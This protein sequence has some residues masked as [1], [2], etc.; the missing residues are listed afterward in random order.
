MVYVVEEVLAWKDKIKTDELQEALEAFI[1]SQVLIP[2]V[3]QPVGLAEI[4]GKS[5]KHHLLRKF[6]VALEQ[7]KESI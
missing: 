6:Q 2:G 1:E 4:Q 7:N 5:L 3:W